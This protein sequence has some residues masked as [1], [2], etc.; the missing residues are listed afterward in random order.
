MGQQ[1]GN[2]PEHIACLELVMP[3]LQLIEG[4]QFILKQ[5]AEDDNLKQNILK[6]MEIW[7][8]KIDTLQK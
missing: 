8:K 2:Q 5:V 4:I 1:I 7:T 6:M 3:T